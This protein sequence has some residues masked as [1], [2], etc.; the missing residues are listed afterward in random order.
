MKTKHIHNINKSFFQATRSEHTSSLVHKHTKKKVK[1][2][3]KE[4]EKI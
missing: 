2:K 3:K 1:E 4:K